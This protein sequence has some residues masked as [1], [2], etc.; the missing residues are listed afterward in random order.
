MDKEP[1][2]SPNHERVS[3]APCN[4]INPKK[5]NIRAGKSGSAAWM[6]AHHLSAERGTGLRAAPTKG[7]TPL[8]D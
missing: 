5:A 2:H 1:Q 4:T 6:N 8:R 7:A 3:E